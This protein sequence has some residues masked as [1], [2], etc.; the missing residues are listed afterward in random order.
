MADVEHEPDA[1]LPSDSDQPEPEAGSDDVLDELSK[2]AAELESEVPGAEEA[3]DQPSD[4]PSEGDLAADTVPEPEEEVSSVSDQPAAEQ[5]GPQAGPAETESASEEA[6]SDDVLDELSKLAAELESEVPESE[7]VVEPADQPSDPGALME[8][9]LYAAMAESTSSSAAAVDEETSPPETAETP[10]AE[11]VSEP[12]AEAGSEIE[13]E[14]TG[15]PALE[16]EQDT[17]EVVAEEAVPQAEAERETETDSFDE[18]VTRSQAE[19]ETEDVAVEEAVPQ[20]E[21]EQES[22]VVSPDETDAEAEPETDEAAAAETV[23]QPEI[24]Q[25]AGEAP[26]EPSD[27]TA[28]EPGPEKEP[29][30]RRIRTVRLTPRAL[31]S[32]AAGIAAAL[33]SY[34]I[35]SLHVVQPPESLV[36]QLSAKETAAETLARSR[37][38]AADGVLDQAVALLERSIERETPSTERTD[39]SYL[40]AELADRLAGPEPDGMTL[41]RL[42]LRYEA[43]LTE[44]AGHPRTP[45]AL[46]RLGTIYMKQRNFEAARDRFQ[47]I[48]TKFPDYTDVDNVQIS[49]AESHFLEGTNRVAERLLLR[50]IPSGMLAKS[51][52]RAEVLLGRVLEAGGQTE[53]ARRVYVR[54]AEQNPG[55][56]AAAISTERLAGIAVERGDYASAVKLLEGLIGDTVDVASNDRLVLE[57]AKA[58]YAQKDYRRAENRCRDLMELFP[59]SSYT[60][61]A[62]ALLTRTLA[63]RDRLAEAEQIAV[64]GTVRF[65]ES[66]AIVEALADLC[67]DRED[68]ENAQTYYAA[69]VKLEPDRLNAR[70]RVGESAM[71]L[72]DYG[73]AVN[74]FAIAANTEPVRDRI[75]YQAHLRLA[76]AYLA[77]GSADRA[78]ESLLSY[79]TE[80]ATQELRRPI[81]RRL[82]QVYS[83]LGLKADAAR[84]FEQIAGSSTTD[85]I[86]ID[87]ASA[88]SSAGEWNRARLLLRRANID[89]MSSATAYRAMLL[90]GDLMRRIG[91]LRGSI[92][93]LADAHSRY[94][95]ARTLAGMSALLDAYLADD[96]TASARTL[97]KELRGWAA[98]NGSTD[99]FAAGPYLHWGDYLFEQGDYKGAAD[100]FSEITDETKAAAQAREWAQYQY[101]NCQFN[102]EQFSE[103]ERLYAQF[104]EQ[105][106]QS[107]WAKAAQTKIQYA[108]AERRLRTAG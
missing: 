56:E 78:I 44:N 89:N 36:A 100:V 62:V 27:E 102:L 39:M 61:D 92:A 35:L 59:D 98:Q 21:A 81:L 41:E 6:G 5:P 30:G 107:L 22:P 57:L 55:T 46:H 3:G 75:Q 29:V 105:H 34:T 15:E 18:M 17:D 87:A 66:A 96:K 16:L 79:L 99:T 104:V 85:E 7:E 63:A 19:L 13:P 48:V 33:V 45:A 95:A 86:L 43:A 31:T 90:K 54:L 82:A 97:V 26:A 4:V 23:P 91:D 67:F 65:P 60:A 71:K 8:D 74:A 20:A 11:P 77:A 76:D 52:V 72:E 50:M 73:A 69:A 64:E 80:F 37:S 53:S 93:Q 101:A 84:V 38:L 83:E 94:P 40:A 106:K 25:E 51:R 58:Y 103:A 32:L 108:A 1:G 47:D 28:A 14:S 68:F 49:I 70:V 42:R 88:Y 24:E 12:S 9:P 10:S 2:L